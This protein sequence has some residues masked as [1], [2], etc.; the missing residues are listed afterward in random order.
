MVLSIVTPLLTFTH[1]LSAQVF[2][3]VVNIHTVLPFWKKDTKAKTLPRALLHSL[4]LSSHIPV[5]ATLLE[6][7]IGTCHSLVL[8]SLSFF[9][10]ACR[11][12]YRSC[13]GHHWPKSIFW[14]CLAALDTGDHSLLPVTL[15][16]GFCD[17]VSSWFSSHIPLSLLGPLSSSI[18]P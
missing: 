8:I 15:F 10:P 18:W 11:H 9:L 17:I 5:S 1:L 3:S 7:G 16:L 2:P 6:R 14:D 13:P 4:Q 12:H